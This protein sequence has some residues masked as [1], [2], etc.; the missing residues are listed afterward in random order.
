MWVASSEEVFDDDCL[1]LCR[2]H[3]P[4]AFP[5][6][7][8]TNGRVSPT[9][10]SNSLGDRESTQMNSHQFDELTH[11]LNCSSDRLETVT[12]RRSPRRANVLWVKPESP[13]V[14]A[15]DQP[16]CRARSL[17]RLFFSGPCCWW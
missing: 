5:R 13:P 1:E 14:Y 9:K 11:C 15:P 2:A 16:G 6:F 17:A 7:M 8:A 10:Q 12:K 4:L 3:V